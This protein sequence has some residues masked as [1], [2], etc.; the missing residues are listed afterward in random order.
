MG[1]PV[2]VVFTT[3]ANAAMAIRSHRKL[4]T[5]PDEQ[6]K[7]L[8]TFSRNLSIGGTVLGLIGCAATAYSASVEN[9]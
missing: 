6:T 2:T 1:I 3:V 8:Y 7:K 4:K 9:K 5:A